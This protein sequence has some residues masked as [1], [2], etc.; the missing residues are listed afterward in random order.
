M[1]DGVRCELVTFG[2]EARVEEH[3]GLRIT[4]CAP[5]ATS[6]APAHPVAPALAAVVR[7]ADVVHAPPAAC[8]AGCRHSLARARRIPVVV[9]DHGLAGGDWLG[10]LPHLFS[11]FLPVSEYSARVLH[12][13]PGRTTVVWEGS[14]PSGSRPVAVPGTACC[15]SAV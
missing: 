2:R 9:T 11:R 15:S 12:A 13:P 4:F 10:L 3:D 8:R 5:C 7:R 14:T 1:V 6:A